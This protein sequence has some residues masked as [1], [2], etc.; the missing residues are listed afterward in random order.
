MFYYLIA[1]IAGILIAIMIQ[2]NGVL[3][4]S[5]GIYTSIVIVHLMGLLTASI[6]AL[7]KKEKP[8]QF[9]KLPFYMYIGGT[10]G[11]LTT[12]FN[13]EAFNIIS[14]SAILAISL[15]SQAITAIFIDAFGLFGMPKRGF[16][17]YK[18][19][20]LI[21]VFIGIVFML[22]PFN[23]TVQSIV[24]IVLTLLTGPTCNISR[25]TNAAL[26]DKTSLANSTAWNY[27]TGFLVSLIV[28]LI[29]GWIRK[30]PLFTGNYVFDKRLW[31]YLG[32]ALGAITIFLTNM[33]FSKIDTLYATLFL[34]TGQVF[35]GIVI[36][37]I[38]K[39]SFDLFLTIGAL[40][41]L[42]GLIFNVIYEK[43]K[44]KNENNSKMLEPK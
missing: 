18:I 22:Y 19:I 7:I 4:V 20:G 40:L 41:S 11:Y 16:K 29:V 26:A 12:V 39:G 32:G 23:F 17:W 24:A 2:I 25:A 34:F 6:I 8:I 27:A 28:V 33:M 42:I 5:I 36:D 10:I 35:T 30:E 31:I 13:N 21:I 43:I 14:I 15:F 38:T 3:S 9:K 44:K 37:I 1:I